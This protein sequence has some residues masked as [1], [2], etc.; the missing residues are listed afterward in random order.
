MVPSKNDVPHE[1]A[2]HVLALLGL[3]HVLTQRSAVDPASVAAEGTAATAVAATGVL[4]GDIVLWG[5]G[6]DDLL[7]VNAGIHVYASD[8]DEIAVNISN[9]I[10]AAG[11]GIDLASATW[12][13]VVLR[14]AQ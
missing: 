9:N 10:V 12:T 8:D 1:L 2:Q 14:A 3:T 4:P 6:T 5:V 13:F 7:S 11:A